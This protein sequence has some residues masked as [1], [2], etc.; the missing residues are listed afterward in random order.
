[1]FCQVCGG[2]TEERQKDGSMRPVCTQCG[3]VTYVDP[4]LAVAVVIERNGK[5]L[6]GKRAAWTRAA[7]AWSFPSGFVD[8]GEVVEDA[9]RREVAEETGLD[10]TIGPLLGVWSAT[11]EPVVLLVWPS[12]S[13]SGALRP[14]DDLTELEWFT[15]DALPSLAFDHDLA[16]IARWQEWRLTGSHLCA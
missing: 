7:G 15:P 5:L 11:G 6:L 10:V 3:R 1:M 12:T 16:I 9:A 4:K 13:V 2:K 8:R 14:G